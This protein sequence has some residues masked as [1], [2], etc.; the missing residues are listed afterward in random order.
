MQNYYT[1]VIQKCAVAAEN[2]EFIFLCVQA[3]TIR[4]FCVI[5]NT[6]LASMLYVATNCLARDQLCDAAASDPKKLDYVC[7]SKQQELA[8]GV[9]GVDNAVIDMEFCP[10]VNIS[11]S[12][13]DFTK[14]SQ[15]PCRV[16]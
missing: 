10:I 8:M 13:A 5:E 11:N 2:R 12:P 6:L 3:K 14:A 7:R 1:A 15:L 9:I 4:H 16:N